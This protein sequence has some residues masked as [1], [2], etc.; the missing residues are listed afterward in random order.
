MGIMQNSV[1]HDLFSVPAYGTLPIMSEFSN[2]ISIFFIFFFIS[3][4]R[5]YVIM[6]CCRVNGSLLRFFAAPADPAFQPRLAG[7][8][9]DYLPFPPIMA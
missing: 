9:F 7:C 8:R 4:I 5:F 2:S 3:F 1:I 6:F